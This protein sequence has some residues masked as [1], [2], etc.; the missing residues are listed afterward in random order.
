MPQQYYN[1][2][3]EYKIHLQ[4]KYTADLLADGKSL[5]PSVAVLECIY[6]KKSIEIAEIIRVKAGVFILSDSSERYRPLL[7]PRFLWRLVVDEERVKVKMRWDKLTSRRQK[8]LVNSLEQI[9]ISYEDDERMAEH[10]FFRAQCYAHI[11]CFGHPNP[12]NPPFI[13]DKKMSITLSDTTPFGTKQRRGSVLETACLFAKTTMMMNYLKMELST[14]SFASSPYLVPLS[15]KIA[16]F[17]SKYKDEA[18]SMLYKEEHRELKLN[19]A[20]ASGAGEKEECITSV[21]KE[22]GH[23]KDS[24]SNV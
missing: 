17:M 5:I 21:N 3:D 2:V 7:F 15:K 20:E 6:S 16:E 12:D 1:S 11:N 18:I 10:H 14:S 19:S 4:K 13:K 24:G 22:S 23:P 9:D 8:D